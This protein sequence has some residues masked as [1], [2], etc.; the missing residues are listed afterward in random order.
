ML[1][2]K[3]ESQQKQQVTISL[4]ERTVNRIADYMELYHA[5]YGETI[6][7]GSLIEEILNTAMNRDKTFKRF[8]KNRALE[9]REAASEEST[10]APGQ[11]HYGVN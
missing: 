7:R 2:K 8:E 6:D 4:Q 9:K 10:S 5:E 11:T 1:V 3:I